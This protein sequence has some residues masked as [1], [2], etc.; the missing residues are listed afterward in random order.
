MGICKQFIIRFISKA[1]YDYTCTTICV[2][3]HE[4]GC[5]HIKIEL[6]VGGHPNG[7]YKMCYAVFKF[8]QVKF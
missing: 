2:M 7:L 4:S 6:T 1:Y 8:Y 3:F 5:L